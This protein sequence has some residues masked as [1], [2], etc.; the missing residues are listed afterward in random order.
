MHT[1]EKQMKKGF[2]DEKAE[3]LANK[4]KEGYEDYIAKSE[5]K[6]T[7]DLREDT[8]IHG[9]MAGLRMA[10]EVEEIRREL[11]ATE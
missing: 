10:I 9:L 2:T 7:S 1:G 11:E 4:I 6:T 3:V 5:D 8:F